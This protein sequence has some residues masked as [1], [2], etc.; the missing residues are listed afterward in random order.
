[1]VHNLIGS[2]FVYV[3]KLTKN[4]LN[5][6]KKL[7]SEGYHIPEFFKNFQVSDGRNEHNKILNLCYA[8]TKSGT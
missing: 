8:K 7:R 1:M 6:I 4:A 3:E 5:L 2:H